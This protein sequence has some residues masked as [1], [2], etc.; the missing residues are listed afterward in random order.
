MALDD[1]IVAAL[2][3]LVT[4]FGSSQQG[5]DVKR[6]ITRPLVAGYV[7]I[8]PAERSASAHTRRLQFG[9]CIANGIT[10]PRG[11]LERNEVAVTCD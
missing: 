10:L 11:E 5:N 4:S 3:G 6:H 9:Y 2:I 7:P 8:R 1:A